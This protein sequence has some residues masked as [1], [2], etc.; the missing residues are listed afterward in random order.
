M[1]LQIW[2]T[3]S[4]YRR[5]RSI[6]LKISGFCSLQ[7]IVKCWLLPFFSVISLSVFHTNIHTQI[8]IYTVFYGKSLSLRW[9][10]LKTEANH[11]MTY[12]M[13]RCV[14]WH[15]LSSQETKVYAVLEAIYS[16]IT[17]KQNFD[18]KLF[19]FALNI[20]RVSSVQGEKITSPLLQCNSFCFWKYH[21]TKYSLNTI[22]SITI[23]KR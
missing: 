1:S 12:E 16:S 2:K 8:L 4:S 21:L 10:S 5:K 7:A 14:L 13:S 18:R 9:L 23:A 3:K 20:L 22:Y 19:G 11:I 6:C 17:I 15:T